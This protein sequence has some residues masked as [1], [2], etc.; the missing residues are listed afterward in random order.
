MNCYTRGVGFGRMEI[1][2]CGFPG[3]RRGGH[4]GHRHGRK[5]VV[6]GRFAEVLESHTEKDDW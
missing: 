5:Q 4:S 3:G 6:E 1:K 2:D